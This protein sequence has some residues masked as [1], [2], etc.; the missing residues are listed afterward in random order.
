MIDLIREY[1]RK[2]QLKWPSVWE[3]MAWVNTE[4]AEVYEL[5]LARV[6]G[7]TR[8]N[9]DKHTSWDREKFAE[10]LGDC[11]LMLL[12]AGYIEGV[13]PIEAMAEKIRI[14]LSED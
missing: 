9:P 11:I 8:N 5:L 13:D 14:K 3:A 6:G 7:W 10:E 12:V 2:R 4:I 1:Y